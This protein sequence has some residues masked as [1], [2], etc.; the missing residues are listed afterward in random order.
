M[1]QAAR[2]T[3]KLRGNRLRVQARKLGITSDTALADHLGVARTT[4]VR[5][6]KGDLTPGENFIA[7]ALT[8]FPDLRFEDL[9]QV[10]GRSRKNGTEAAA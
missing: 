5:M 1:Q 8:A 2:P 9:F 10:T 4:V 6:Y 7:A 3:I